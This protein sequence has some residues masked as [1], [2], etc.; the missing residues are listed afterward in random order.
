[1]GVDQK[2]TPLK[3]RPEINHADFLSIPAWFVGNAE[4]TLSSLSVCTPVAGIVVEERTE[5]SQAHRPA[6]WL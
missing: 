4:P 5:A 1:M 6:L 3:E 2:N